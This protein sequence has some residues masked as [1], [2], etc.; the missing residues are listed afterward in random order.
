MLSILIS[1]FA[2]AS[3]QD[4]TNLVTRVGFLAEDVLQHPIVPGSL[5]EPEQSQFYF[6]V[7]AQSNVMQ[8]IIVT[9]A[10]GTKIPSEHGRKI[11]LTG[12]SSIFTVGGKPHT[13]G[14]Y[15]NEVISLRKWKY[16]KDGDVTQPTNAP[17]SSPAT[18]S[19]R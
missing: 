18:G 16:L 13:K 17:Y 7:G 15:S 11:E 2:S 5:F 14:E 3:P 12:I 8:Q 10:V 4:E 6:D 1:G 19:K 9:Y